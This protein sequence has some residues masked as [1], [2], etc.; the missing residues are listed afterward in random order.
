MKRT[1][2]NGFV[3]IVVIM[4]M[5]LFA[6]ALFVLTASSAKMAFESKTAALQAQSRNLTASAIAWAE[7]NSKKLDQLEDGITFQLD[8]SS[9]KT[10]R[11]TCNITP[12][13]VEYGQSEIKI[14]T[15][16]TRGRRTLAQSV[17]L[18]TDGYIYE[19][20]RKSEL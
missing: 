5:S 11:A 2:K 1:R 3:I 14:N 12:I 8:I 16:C 7:H 9:L 17:T 10:P 4:L 13:K 18:G 19:R 6:M 20:I 15:R